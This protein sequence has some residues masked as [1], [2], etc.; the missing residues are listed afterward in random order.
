MSGKLAPE[1]NGRVN[2]AQAAGNLSPRLNQV[3]ARQWTGSSGMR[4]AAGQQNRPASRHARRATVCLLPWQLRWLPYGS[5]PMLLSTDHLLS[6][7]GTPP[8][9]CVE[10][11]AVT[12]GLT[13][14]PAVAGRHIARVAVRASR[15]VEAIHLASPPVFRG[16]Q[17]WT[18]LH[19][20]YYTADRQGPSTEIPT[21]DRPFDG[22]VF[23]RLPVDR[24]KHRPGSA[25]S[26][27]VT[28][29]S[30]P[31]EPHKAR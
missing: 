24:L 21:L 22:H 5:R 8:P 29:R 6:K 18:S 25:L 13:P 30:A 15:S 11:T 7:M 28:R 3:N 14:P 27:T 2:R 23:C 19:D 31:P 4:F 16:E 20:Y 10:S 26:R 1:K 9:R 17:R 12:M